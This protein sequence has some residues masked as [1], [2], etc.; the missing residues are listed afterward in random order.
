MKHSDFI[1]NK[2]RGKRDFKIQLYRVEKTHPEYIMPLHWHNEF[3]IIRII[4]GCF[5]LYVD[6]IPYSMV[7]GD[8]AFVN[9]KSLHRGEPFDCTYECIVV[10]FSLLKRKSDIT[11]F[12]YIEPLLNSEM[13]FRV[14]YNNYST[15]LYAVI[16]ALFLLLETECEFYELAVVGNLYL[17]LQLAYSEKII[18]KSPK[19][20]KNATQTAIVSDLIEWI[21]ENF[22]EHISL[23][24]LAKKAGIS[25][26]YLC[27]VFKLY[28]GKSPIE[29]VNHV[30]VEG[31]CYDIAYGGKSITD[32]ALENGFNDV[33]YFCKVFK[34][35]TGLTA[36]EYVA[37][38]K[39]KT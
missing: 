7:A 14:L 29:Y 12:S 28:T 18:C 15:K 32:I 13:S 39:K 9:C 36:K 22:T 30:R 23:Q 24:G 34:K 37:C 6:N 8:V 3:E 25:P 16:N 2:E 11:V 26:N 35:Y 21:E 20:G 5:T 19:I 4:S 27:R 31:V 33:S 38:C 10:D 1:E 17:L